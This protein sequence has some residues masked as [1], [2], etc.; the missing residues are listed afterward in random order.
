MPVGHVGKG[1]VRLDVLPGGLGSGGCGGRFADCRENE[2]GKAVGVAGREKL[3]ESLAGEDLP[4][5][6]DV[7][8]VVI[9]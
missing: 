5:A 3:A 9:S 1:K 6:G 8:V 2:L 7:G 4:V